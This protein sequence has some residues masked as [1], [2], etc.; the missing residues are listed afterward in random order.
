MNTP[1][2]SSYLEGTRTLVSKVERPELKMAVAVLGSHPSPSLDNISSKMSVDPSLM[3][4]E[5]VIMASKAMVSVNTRM[6][7]QSICMQSNKY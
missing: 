1:V 6:C 3:L 2:V 4:G 5:L 7:M